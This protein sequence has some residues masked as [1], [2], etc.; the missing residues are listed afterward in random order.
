M[1]VRTRAGHGE[2]K[3]LI[4]S[5]QNKVFMVLPFYFMVQAGPFILKIQLIREFLQ[6]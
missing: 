2:T 3:S 6:P 4:L 1:I 5:V